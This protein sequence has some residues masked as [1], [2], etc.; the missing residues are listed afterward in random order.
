MRYHLMLNQH[1]ATETSFVL[2]DK[3]NYSWFSVFLSFLP[4][5]PEFFVHFHKLTY[6]FIKK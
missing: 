4:L 5:G 2:K 1:L 6:S 3:V